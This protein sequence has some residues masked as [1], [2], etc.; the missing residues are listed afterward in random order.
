MQTCVDE[1][2]ALAVHAGVVG[3]EI[4]AV[5]GLVLV[6]VLMVAEQ[7]VGA[8]CELAPVLVGTGPKLHEAAAQLC[9]GLDVLGV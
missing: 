2:A 3:G 1:V 6:V 5:F 8:V 4:A 9:L 7:L